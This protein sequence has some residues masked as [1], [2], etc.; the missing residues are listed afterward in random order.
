[1]RRPRSAG[2]LVALFIVLFAMSAAFFATDVGQQ[3]LV[4]QWERTAIAFGQ[5]VDDARY[6][7]FQELSARGV[8]YAAATALAA[9]P[10]T[11]IVL[12]GVIYAVFTGLRGGQATYA[13]VLAVVAHAGVIQM[14]RALVTTPVNYA[15][16]SMASPT[17]LVLFFTMVDEASPVARFFGLVDV[18]VVWWLVV[19]AI[20]TAVLYG[21]RTSRMAALFVGTYVVIALLLAGT[22]AVLGGT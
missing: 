11:A 10:V 14:A 17:T 19:L 22:M 16:E 7:R 21:G 3:A 13:Q 6:A 20:G 4:D 9:G 8:P 5:G 12:A 15:R 18:F 2:L 1:M